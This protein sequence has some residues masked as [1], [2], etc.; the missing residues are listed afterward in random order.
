MKVL[1]IDYKTLKYA[2]SFKLTKEKY[3]DFIDF[4][5][6]N[7]YIGT[8]ADKNIFKLIKNPWG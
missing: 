2:T 4:A 1:L 7:K 3:L 8:T 5:L 6:T